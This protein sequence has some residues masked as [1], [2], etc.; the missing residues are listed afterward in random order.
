MRTT[1][2][3]GVRYA[4]ARG[5][6]NPGVNANRREIYL[7]MNG[8]NFSA[9]SRGAGGGATRAD[10]A[11]AAPLNTWVHIAATATITSATLATWNLYVNGVL[12][13]TTA[14]AAWPVAA[15]PNAYWSIGG[16]S[17]N[18]G[19]A[20]SQWAGNIDEV[21]MYNYALTAAQITAV[22]GQRHACPGPNLSVIKTVSVV[23]DVV[24]AANDKAIPGATMRYTITLQNSSGVYSS[25][26]VVVTDNFNDANVTYVP[27]TAVVSNGAV[28]V[29]S[30]AGGVGGKSDRVV[31][32]TSVPASGTVTVTFD[33][34]VD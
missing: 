8:N 31:V 19:A 5:L 18:N 22:M 15:S 34:T 24:S 23:D 2:S 20:A 13:A 25:D 9:G 1:S 21:Q 29:V 11:V 10:S 3:G 27:G 6:Y 7:G 17:N 16:L 32:N 14:G 12:V 4:I 28:P 30:D 33:V 26:S